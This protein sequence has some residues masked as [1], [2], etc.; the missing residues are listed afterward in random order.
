MRR[1]GRTWFIV[2]F[3]SPAVAFYFLFVGWPIVHALELSL[4]E[5][6]GLS[7]E[8][9]YVGLDNFR[10]LL[11][12]PIFWRSVEHNLAFLVIGGGLMLTLAMLIAHALQGRGLAVRF[13]RGVYLFPQ[14]ISLVVVSILWMF[15][16]NPSFGVWTSLR[17]AMGH[18]GSGPAVLGME[19]TAL[20]AV[21]LAYV[22]YGAGFYIMLL[23]AG[24]RA[25]PSEVIEASELDGARGWV[26]FRRV[27]LPL[28]WGVM[29][30][31]TV[32]T[33]ISAFNVFVLVYLMTVGGPDRSSEVMLTYLYELAFK[34]SH[35]GLATAL[36][37]LNLLVVL[38]VSFVIY[39]LYRKDPTGARA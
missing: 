1:R 9:T 22:W 24:I 10:R 25:V 17:G 34:E 15:L 35:F 16:Y 20:G 21:I 14:V 23:S 32:Y 6:R 12:D 7:E 39:G 33:V 2:G 11:S 38:L 8:K 37:V 19:S 30:V 26:R 31:S 36:G 13:L 3:L 27:T 28:L 5:W 18:P 4:F 29:R